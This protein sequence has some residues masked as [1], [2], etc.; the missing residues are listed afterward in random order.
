MSTT[1]GFGIL[2][3]CTMALAW[4]A[5]ELLPRRPT[6]GLKGLLMLGLVAAF[7][8][9]WLAAELRIPLG[10][11]PRGVSIGAGLIGSAGAIL[12]ASLWALGRRQSKTG[13]D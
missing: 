12:V 8:F 9:G 4:I 6:G 2:V 11:T 3:V 10:P 13:A 1:I 7:F 5:E